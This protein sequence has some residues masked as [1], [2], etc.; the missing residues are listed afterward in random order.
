M[1]LHIIT[2]SYIILER[3][4]FKES[5]MGRSYSTHVRMRNTAPVGCLHLE[6]VNLGCYD[7]LCSE[8]SP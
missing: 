1:V 4:E 5:D 3:D 6:Y 2:V 7:V 8:I